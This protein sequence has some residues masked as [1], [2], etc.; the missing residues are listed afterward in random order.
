[1]KSH[2]WIISMTLTKITEDQFKGNDKSQHFY[3]KSDV[4]LLEAEKKIVTYK[5]KR[6]EW[7]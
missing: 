6:L 2:C 7:R 5:T 3:L 4:S 1:M